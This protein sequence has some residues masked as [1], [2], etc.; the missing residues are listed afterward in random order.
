[1]CTCSSCL[2]GDSSSCPLGQECLH[3]DSKKHWNCFVTCAGV[4]DDSCPCGYVCDQLS[5]TSLCLPQSL[6][7]N[8][9]AAIAHNM[10]CAVSTLQC[11]VPRAYQA[12]YSAQSQSRVSLIVDGGS[13]ALASTSSSLVKGR[14]CKSNSDCQDGN[15]CTLDWCDSS[16]GLCSYTSLVGCD[17]T[18]QAVRQQSTPYA[19][20]ELYFRNRSAQHLLLRKQLSLNSTKISMR[21]LNNYKIPKLGFS[22]EFFG[23][24]VGQAVVSATGV[25][26]LPPVDDCTASSC[27]LFSTSSNVVAPWFASW[28]ASASG[29]M[30][31][32]LQSEGDG[33]EIHGMRGS[34][35]HVMFSDMVPD[36]APSVAANQSNSSS[37]SASIFEDGSVR[38]SYFD[39]QPLHAHSS[40]FSGLWGAVVTEEPTNGQ[41]RYHLENVS[42]LL[43]GEGGVDVLYCPFSTVACIPQS[44]VSAG[45]LVSI[46]WNGTDSCSALGGNETIGLFCE[47]AG[48]AVN[49]TVARMVPS[50][51]NTSEPSVVQCEVPHMDF[52]NGQVLFVDLV[53]EAVYSSSALD[54]TWRYLSDQRI[55]YDSRQLKTVYGVV[56]GNG[57]ELARTNL[58][59]RYYN[60]SSS[61]KTCGCSALPT[62]AGYYCDSLN[63]CGGGNATKDCAGSPFGSA[64]E[65]GCGVCSGGLTGVTPVFACPSDSGGNFLSLISQTIILL[66]II[67]CM[68]FIT[69]TASFSIR[70][71]LAQRHLEEGGGG[72]DLFE[73]YTGGELRDVPRTTPTG[74]S[75][76][77]CEA[78]GQVVFTTEFYLAHKKAQLEAMH[79]VQGVS[80]EKFADGVSVP[81]PSSSNCDCSIC[82]MDILEGNVC[83][84]LPDPCGHVFHLACIDQWFKQST[85]CP[86][87]KR[88][89]KS[90]LVGDDEED[91]FPVRTARGNRAT[92][93]PPPHRPFVALQSMNRIRNTLF[94]QSAAHRAT[95]DAVSTPSS[96]SAPTPMNVMSSAPS[97][98]SSSQSSGG[99][100][101]MTRVAFE[102]APGDEGVELVRNSDRGSVDL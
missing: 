70:R 74:L 79:G 49:R 21:K 75:E 2:G 96:S 46:R 18:P 81:P 43:L 83:R 33:T 16:T 30:S 48:G 71:M 31:V 62:Y 25:V 89:M 63:V 73:E 9:K 32:R 51:L 26:S 8:P 82:L 69:S 78:L 93:A 13:S 65:S 10:S 54:D 57:T 19:Y 87:C 85:K 27:V 20:R 97:S 37:F 101:A 98:S 91:D 24:L 99:G 41:A 47:W 94:Q 14:Y 45:D 102:R 61:R 40:D 4:G 80:S 59:V 12:A 88:N 52:S 44:C 17:S 22:V 50:L 68:T 36:S 60:D 95:E 42:R 7:D 100:V 35:L 5:S 92:H 39:V 77:E 56:L 58:Q 76:F 15:V 90:I 6:I 72:D 64:Y 38:L 84:V 29:S 55:E 1:M 28:N 67:C 11:H 3:I 23:N 34:A 53:V 66:M 86:L